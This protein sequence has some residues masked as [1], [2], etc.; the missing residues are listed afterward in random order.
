MPTA[1]TYLSTAKLSKATGIGRETLR[2][3]ET[4][5]L[6]KP[7][8]RTAAGYRQFDANTISRIA[9]IKQTQ[10]AGFTLK[11]IKHLLQLNADQSDTCGTLSKILDGKL[12]QLDELLSAMHAQRQ[13]LLV[14]TKT[15]A[16]QNE[17]RQCNF[18]S[19]KSGC[20]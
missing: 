13:A 12:K 19:T 20:C 3:Y 9:F 4:R 17:S 5:G 18:V 7:A 8:A 6:I 14:L 1:H 15:C 11:E 10:Q 2:F 16:S